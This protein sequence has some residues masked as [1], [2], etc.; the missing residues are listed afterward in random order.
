MDLQEEALDR[1]YD[2]LPADATE[3]ELWQCRR[4]YVQVLDF[5]ASYQPGLVWLAQAVQQH[6]ASG[7]GLLLHPQQWTETVNRGLRSQPVHRCAGH[8]GCPAG[9]GRSAWPAL[10][11][12]L[13]ALEA[14]LPALREEYDSTDLRSLFSAVVPGGF[15]RGQYYRVN[16]PYHT[17]NRSC[18]APTL[19][20]CSALRAFD[21]TAKSDDPKADGG[22]QQP[23][24]HD[25]LV[26]VHPRIVSVRY[27]VLRPG[28]EFK[29]HT[30]RSNQKIKVHCGV[31][32]A[33]Q[34]ALRLANWSIPWVEGHC[35]L[36][37]TSYEHAIA[38]MHDAPTRVV[39][40][41]KMS[42]PDLN[43]VPELTE[44]KA[45][46]AGIRLARP[47]STAA[48]ASRL[49]AQLTAAIRLTNRT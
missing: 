35:M 5:L 22:Y 21:D 6:M 29:T 27:V 46:A 15:S 14:E 47:Q 42:H 44:H 12:A 7:L 30:A 34:V 48:S 19:R 33:G 3:E 45:E 32:N 24:P 8:E 40:E 2:Q 13:D 16:I 18:A 37:D 20:L 39:L 9:M 26:K 25:G 17:S 4:F 38:A 1:L 23:S 28:S 10:D 43:H 11:R 41:I 36:I 49:H 31:H